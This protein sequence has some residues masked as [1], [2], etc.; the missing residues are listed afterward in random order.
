VFDADVPGDSAVEFSVPGI[1]NP[2][3]P[4]VYDFEPWTNYY[5]QVGGGGTLD[6][7]DV[8]EDITITAPT[9][10][11]PD[12]GTGT[13]EDPYIYSECFT[14]DESAYY[15]LGANI[16]GVT[17][18]CIEI[19]A[20]DVFIDGAGFTIGSDGLQLNQ[21]VETTGYDRISISNIT[22]DQFYDGIYLWDSAGPSTISDVTITNSA[23]DGFDLQG[24][25]DLTISGSTTVSDAADDGIEIGVYD[26][27][28]DTTVYS[29]DITITDVTLTDN[30]DVG[31][32]VFAVDG[33]TVNGTTTISGGGDD[34]IY[35]VGFSDPYSLEDVLNTDIVIT[36]VTISDYDGGDGIYI[37]T[38]EGITITD[39]T[40]SDVDADGIDIN[41]VNDLTI[42]GSTI[43]DV[44]E[45]GVELY[46]VTLV[47]VTDNIITPNTV[48][49]DDDNEG[50]SADYI[51][52]GLFSGNT[53]SHIDS[54]GMN[55]ED[56]TDVTVT[57]N[58]IDDVGSDGV[59]FAGSGE[60]ENITITNN[61]MTNI[62]DNGIEIDEMTTGTFTGNTMYVFDKGIA[63]DDSSDITFT[64]N[65][66]YPVTIESVVV[67]TTDTESQSTNIIDAEDSVSSDDNYFDYELPFTFNYLGRDITDI[68][69]STNGTI[70][71]LEDG[72]SCDICDSYGNYNDYLNRDLIFANFDDL[73]MNTNAGDYVA[74]FNESDEYII[75][76]W[77]GS[78]YDD[79][80]S[81]TYPLRFQVV[82][83]PSGEVQWNFIETDFSEYG[84]D[85]FSGAYAEDESRTY[86]VGTAISTPSSYVADFSDLSPEVTSTPVSNIGLDLDESEDSTY[87]GNFITAAKWVYDENGSNNI[88]NDGDSGNTYYFTDG[89]GAWTVYDIV[90][91]DRNGFADTGADLPFNELTLGA[92]IWEG[93]GQ[94]EYPATETQVS[95]RRRSS[96]SPESRAYARQVFENYYSDRGE[97]DESEPA[98]NTDKNKN[99]TNEVV[100]ASTEEPAPTDNSS[101][102]TNTCPISQILTQN[103]KIGAIDGQFHNYTG[104]TVT[105]VALLQQYI[106]EILADAYAQ[107]AGPVD[108]IFGVLTKQGVERMQQALLERYGQ[109][110]GSY[111]I[112]GIVGPFT[113]AAIN[114]WCEGSV[115]SS[116]E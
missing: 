80:D 33:L 44:G 82:M 78:T 97:E 26:N 48:G 38:A 111:G 43:T 3:T 39:A 100:E 79:D 104:E 7:P 8:M 36:D 61:M 110:L 18:D 89:S 62:G 69:I 23:D 71:L 116:E 106:N 1:V 50:I 88:F 16:T 27:T 85:L 25:R 4:G 74:V 66:I 31:I 42:T 102:E 40:I 67:P 46:E 81:D 28:I 53:L 86:I 75:V 24:V 51:I 76:E 34:G 17:G 90:D 108:G 47:T 109:D 9:P 101:E 15:E 73:H 58:T 59:D 83:Y 114:G 96:S 103:M 77:N 92:S 91:T 94:D 95:S 22:I 57:G 20:D 12:S 13:Q 68:T 63:V 60:H 2:V 87:T 35:M 45:N 54:D 99:T 107:A 11:E 56:T 72:E 64:N 10:A 65:T 84:N 41:S 98:G 49:N 70:E 93:D 115:P 55:F 21:G 113:R 5:T 32:E 6:A 37:E 30:A 14:A 112:D 105:E 29:S 19:E 52:A